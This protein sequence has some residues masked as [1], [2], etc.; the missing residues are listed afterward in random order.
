[1][2]GPFAAINDLLLSAL[3][4]VFSFDSKPL[5]HFSEAT[6]DS[7][8]SVAGATCAQNDSS[9]GGLHWWLGVGAG[10]GA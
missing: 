9:L 6:A 3:Y 5:T 7:S 4:W 10:S 1:L 2:D 8:T